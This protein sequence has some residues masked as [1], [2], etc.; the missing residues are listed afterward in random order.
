[1]TPINFSIG[2]TFK[3]MLDASLSAERKKVMPSLTKRSQEIF[4]PRGNICF[5]NIHWG[6]WIARHKPSTSLNKPRRIPTLLRSANITIFPAEHCWQRQ[7]CVNSVSTSE[8]DKT[9]V[10]AEKDN[11]KSERYS[12]TTDITHTV[13]SPCLKYS[14]LFFP[15][16]KSLLDED[17]ISKSSH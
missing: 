10:E 6:W 16:F 2:S 5:V 14:R 9:T 13:V 3:D 17:R 1:M 7:N 4:P 15:P 11:F 12:S 8:V